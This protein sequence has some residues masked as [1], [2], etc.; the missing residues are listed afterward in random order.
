[1][2]RDYIDHAT[3]ESY[4]NW[5]FGST[6]EESLSAKKFTIRTG[7]PALATAFGQV[8]A[9]GLADAAWTSVTGINAN[10]QNFGL[11]G[12]ARATEHAAMFE[13]A[14]HNQTNNDLSKFSTGAYIYPDG[15]FQTLAGFA[16]FAQAQA[17]TA[18]VY[19]RVNT[20]GRRCPHGDLR[21]HFRRRANRRGPRRG[22]TNI[23][24]TTTACSPSSSAK[25]D[26]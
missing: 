23:S 22:R 11:L 8:G 1:M 16:K 6:L 25:A 24:F 10:A 14:F 2:E 12:L 19:A 21:Q 18:A 17:R 26:A 5:Y 4:D 15:S 3:Q 13:T 9:N 7:G 20:W